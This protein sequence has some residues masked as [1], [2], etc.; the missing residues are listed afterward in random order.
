MMIGGENSNTSS[1]MM[2]PTPLIAVV[3]GYRTCRSMQGCIVM[4]CV[5]I[6]VIL[7]MAVSLLLSSDD[8]AVL[9]FAVMT[10][11]IQMPS[12][13]T[14]VLVSSIMFITMHFVG[15]RVV[16]RVLVPI[17]I[18]TTLQYCNYGCCPK[19]VAKR[20]LEGPVQSQLHE[21][22][23]MAGSGGMAELEPVCCLVLPPCLQYSYQ[24]TNTQKQINTYV[25]M[26]INLYLC[27]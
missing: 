9:D 6:V 19:G 10:V 15:A 3:V 20:L 13:T 25:Y 5:V 14:V 12:A 17:M 8:L 27:S 7:A 24:A 11:T 22:H 26:Y 18:L 23:H 2:L 16:A 1:R 21:I 4:S